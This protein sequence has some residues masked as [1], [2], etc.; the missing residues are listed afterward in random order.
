MDHPLILETRAK[1]TVL[2]FQSLS[3]LSLNALEAM[4]AVQKSIAARKAKTLRQVRGL[5]H[6]W[7]KL[8]PGKAKG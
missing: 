6:L 2:S 3:T 8:T 4:T 7:Q 5:R 1:Y